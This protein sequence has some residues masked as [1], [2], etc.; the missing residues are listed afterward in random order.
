MRKKARNDELLAIE[1]KYLEVQKKEELAEARRGSVKDFLAIRTGMLQSALSAEEAENN[2]PSLKDVI[3]N[4]WLFDVSILGVKGDAEQGVSAMRKLDERIIGHIKSHHGDAASSNIKY[5]FSDDGL[6]IAGDTAFAV[7][8]LVDNKTKDVILSLT[9][10][11]KFA[12]NT[13]KIRSLAWHSP[14]TPDLFLVKPTSGAAPLNK[15]IV[16][17][18][19]ISMSSLDRTGSTDSNEEIVTRKVCLSGQ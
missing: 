6:A 11:F 2:A 12:S 13:S 15:P 19:I 9:I 8:E 17:P 14:S 1:E 18:T 5:Q 4:E 16:F 10:H 7:A 3:E